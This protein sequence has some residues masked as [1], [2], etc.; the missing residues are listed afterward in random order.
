MKKKTLLSVLLSFVLMFAACGKTPQDDSSSDTAVNVNIDK[1]TKATLVALVDMDE[2]ERT[3]LE[4]VAQEF[5]KEYP[6]ITIEVITTS[7]PIS[8]VRSG[9]NVDILSVIGENVSFYASEKVLTNL[10]PYKKAAKFNESEYYQSM[11][12]LGKENK[13]GDS[14][15]LPRDYS[16]IVCYYNK[17]IF[18]AC[19]VAY[20]EDTAENPWTWEKYL[21]TCKLL[22]D[23]GKLASGVVTTQAAM[24][25]DILNWGIVSSYGVD[26]LLTSDY[27]LVDNNSDTYRNWQKGMAAARELIEK[28]YT[29]DS[30]TY[31]ADD[32][33]RGAAA[34][35]FL[36]TASTANFTRA[37][38]DY[39]VVPFPAIGNDPKA[40]AG[41]L[42][43]SIAS[44]SKNKDAAWAFLAFIMSEKG[45]LA[46]SKT[47]GFV[48]V[49]KS[50]ATD[51]TSSWRTMLNGKG[52]EINTANMISYQERDVI[53]NWFG[54]LPA[55]AANSYKS[56]Y[57][58]FLVK[59]CDGKSSFAA[60][61]GTFKSKINTLKLEY[62]EYF[63]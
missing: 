56:F 31:G 5:K 27:S 23:S 18:D 11:I 46:L 19:G 3:L 14:Y 29:L 58:E 33:Y 16:R 7:D 54:S 25:Y 60:A 12:D 59:V 52:T 30:N 47:G 21:N 37:G 22:Q 24:S 55:G 44:S 10:E 26:G 45:Q 61:Y 2:K 41:T 63:A 4:T 20:P 40:P 38:L 9:D 32:F 43:Y 13:S 50:L 57:N 49:L 8:Y 6:N 35:A 17:A 15:M 51:E 39:D 34:M 1:N 42:G 53:A 36:S 62:P 48:P 28:G